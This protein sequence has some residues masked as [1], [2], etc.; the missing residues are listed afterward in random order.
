MNEPYVVF[1]FSASMSAAWIV[2][3]AW[4]TESLAVVEAERLKFSVMTAHQREQAKA[5]KTNWRFWEQRHHKGIGG[6]NE[7]PVMWVHVWGANSVGASNPWSY[8]A[9]A[10]LH[11]QG[12]ILDQMVESMCKEENA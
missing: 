3:S 10:R 2:L 9:V 1:G 8:L 7:I 4:A 6:A 11:V 5:P 12:S